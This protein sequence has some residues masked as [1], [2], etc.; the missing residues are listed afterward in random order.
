MRIWNLAVDN[1][2]AVYIFMLII[3]VLGTQAY[4]TMPRE[5]SPDVTVPFVIVS[6]PYVGVSPADIEGLVTQPLEREIKTLKDIKTITSSS[7]EGLST[8]FV[9]FNTGID[10]DEALR[11]VRDK[12]NST[13]P[14]L[15]NDI[16]EP[17]VNEINLSEFPIMYVTVG[18]SLGVARLKEYAD[19][20]KEKFEAIPGVLSADITGGLEP[21]VQ[22]NADVNRMKGYDISFEDITNAIRGENVTIPGG[23]INNGSTDLTVRVPGQYK[24]PKPIADIVVKMRNGQ[25]IYIRDVAELKYSFEDRKTFSRVN[26]KPV[27]T[28]GV[29][30]R[31]GENLIR[32]AD[33]V[34]SIVEKERPLLPAGATL[35]ITND[36]SI[37]VKRMVNELENSIITGMVLVILVL[38]MFF[39]VKNAMLISTSIPLSMLMGFIILSAMGV[40]LNIVVLFTLVLVLGIVVDD[41]IV[42]IENI[43]RHQ[44]EYGEDL[45]QAAKNATREVAVPVATSTFTTVAAFIPLLFW[46]GVVGEFMKYM[47]ITLIATMLSSLFVAYVVS[48]VQGSKFINYKQEI[49]KAKWSLEH[50]SLWRRYNPFTV[51]Y[52][53]VDE[54]LFP[55]AQNNYVHVLR[56]AFKH[57]NLT[58]G[59]AFALLVLSFITFGAF[60][61]GVVFFP[62]TE[63]N[64]VTVGITMPSGT[65]L[66]VTN[67]ATLL[68]EK[69]I[70]EVKG[71]DDIEFRVANVGTSSNPFD[72]G[73]GS[74]ADKASVAV[75]FY[76]KAKRSQ[77]TFATLDRIREATKNIPGAEIKVEKQQMGPPVGAPISIEIAGDDFNRLRTLSEQIQRTIKTIPGIVD[78]KDDYNIGKPEV[79]VIIDREKAALLEMSTGQIASVVRTAINGTEASKFRVGEDE[80]KITVRLREDQRASAEALQNL[81][82]TFMNRRG[83]LMSV[84]IAS[85]ADV[86]RGTGLTGIKRK[87]L[88][89]VITITGNVRG[90][91]AN[92]VLTDVRTR[93]AGFEVP[94][95]YTVNYSGEQKEQDEAAAFLTKALII[96]LLL[97]FLIIVAEFNSVKI[98]TI[99][100]VSVLLSLIGV[101]FGLVITGTAF[102]IVMTGV[103]VIALAG[104][105]VKNAIVLLD[106]TKHIKT[107]SN[108]LEESLLEAGRVRL[109]PVI[110]TAVS[111]ILGIIPLATG[112]DF[113]WREFHFVV[114]AESGGMWR[115]LG[116]AI[117]FGLGVSTFLT[118][119]VVPTY[120]AWAEE[121]T[122][123]AVAKIKRVFRRSA[124][125]ATETP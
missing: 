52:H 53:W 17:I 116:V 33:E 114:G 54:R 112:V 88:T 10:I 78:L 121:K 51:I 84:P 122:A 74:T 101:L 120:Y 110:L 31:A 124:K 43:Y 12:V 108:S 99:I 75:N 24:D 113:S 96:T 26:D 30:K 4:I 81:N 36:Q 97:V 32:I 94:N 58:I 115:P 15:P 62:E 103:G 106:F 73:A 6:I 87:D 3:V 5:A 66:E 102:S 35:N 117:V 16:L 119:V 34:H 9:E 13:K 57:K 63:P 77:S 105:V 69:H 86:V 85:V 93:L 2:V 80:Y 61:A 55:A 70:R 28:V 41:A 37:F 38:F 7:S 29:K 60:S 47:P 72:F 39:G 45:I 95:G 92:D 56:W 18:G 118:L 98:P 107:E 67:Q 123:W 100:M 91:L 49:A 44:Q 14:K 68:V 111:T 90:R 50:P 104:I 40:T 25:P 27:V 82:V 79:Q 64:L 46:P 20:L 48:P 76:E 65:P 89:R 1:R 8:T 21:E 83:V 109:R 125:P 11:R 42:V 19:A 59:G 22:I 23:S 71:V